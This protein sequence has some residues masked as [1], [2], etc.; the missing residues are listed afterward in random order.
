MDNQQD[1]KVK[2]KK[3][4]KFPFMLSIILIVAV[5]LIL[6]GIKGFTGLT[7]LSDKQEITKT[8]I[9]KN[10]NEFSAEKIS[11]N[12]I[13]LGSK[14]EEVAEKLGKPDIQTLHPP[15]IANFEYGPSLGYPNIA[16]LIHM[17]AG[18]VTR[19]TVRKVFNDKLIGDT[20]INYNKEGIYKKFGVPDKQRF[21]PIS[22]TEAVK[23]MT[24]EKKGLDIITDGG[25]TIAFS[26]FY[27]IEE[28]SE[29]VG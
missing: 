4:K 26:L 2:E 9:F 10:F 20:K 28:R 3:Q 8:D 1:Q 17:E 11:V 16:L 6:L 14:A 25:D 27:P 12:G 5:A 7:I 29:L 18:Y 19:I 13:S 15:N 22:N 23:V 24:Y 21:E